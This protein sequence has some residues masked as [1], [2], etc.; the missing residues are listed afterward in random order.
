MAYNKR[1]R[2]KGVPFFRLLVYERVGISLIE[3]YER[4]VKSV[5]LLS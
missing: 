3:V 5:I 1:L 4:G 2:P